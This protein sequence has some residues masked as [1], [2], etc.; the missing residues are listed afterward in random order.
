MVFL[1]N[2]LRAADRG[3]FA[4]ATDRGI[5]TA[6]AWAGGFKC[7]AS[8]QQQ[9]YSQSNEGEPYYI[10]K[11]NNSF[12]FWFPDEYDPD[13]FMPLVHSFTSVIDGPTGSEK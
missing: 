13:H 7:A 11:T 10:L 1:L 5:Y 12:L 4:A 9:Q 8:P 3:L 6:A 2:N